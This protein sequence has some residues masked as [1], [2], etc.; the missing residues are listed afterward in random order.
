[1]ISR[2]LILATL[3][4]FLSYFVM[5]AIISPL[6]IVSGLLAEHFSI[7]VTTATAMFSYLTTGVLIGSFLSIFVNPRFGSKPAI[8]VSCGVLILALLSLR[9]ASH[10]S[11]LAPSFL[12]I[13]ASCGL[14]LASAAIVLT[15]LYSERRRPSALL[16]TDSFYSLAG[17]SIAP[18]AG[19]TIAQSMH[20]ATVYSVALIVTAL[21]VVLAAVTKYPSE[22]KA[23][24]SSSIPIDTAKAWPL[25]VYLIGA[26]LLIYLVIFVFI[27]SWVPAYAVEQFGLTFADAGRLVG[28]FFLGLF[29]G[30]LVIFFLALKVDVRILIAALSIIAGS[31]TLLVW[32]AGSASTLEAA[33]FAL[34]ATTGG[35]LKPL[36]AYGTQVHITPSARLVGFFM[37]STAVGSS[38]SPALGAY[39]VEQSSIK[40]VLMAVSF[41]Y[42]SIIMLILAAIFSARSMNVE[43][44]Q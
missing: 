28:Q 22:E 37:F 36:I 27:Y 19:W 13:G 25:S 41:G 40:T 14:L 38:I 35:L 23:D 43:R 1:M 34:G 21:I 16:A 5:S 4:S 6:G 11:A 7:E 9:F 30:Q 2:D 44:T 33:L 39:I 18:F 29:V 3:T 12:A 8:L 26:A 17:Y 42:A 20:W 15:A 32:T 10:A 31:V 24:T